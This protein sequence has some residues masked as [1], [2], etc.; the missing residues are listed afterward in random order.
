MLRSWRKSNQSGRGTTNSNS[1]SGS[2]GGGGGGSSGGGSGTDTR[3]KKNNK[4]KHQDD[5]GGN[6]TGGKFFRSGN[7]NNNR[8]GGKNPQSQPTTK[9]IRRTSDQPL[10]PQQ[11]ERSPP[12]PGSQENLYPRRQLDDNFDDNDNNTIG[13]CSLYT[14]PSL[15][16][17]QYTHNPQRQHPWQSAGGSRDIYDATKRS[18]NSEVSDDFTADVKAKLGAWQDFRRSEKKRDSQR[19]QQVQEPS[20]TTATSKDSNGPAKTKTK[21][22]SS[23]LKDWTA[24]SSEEKKAL[25]TTTNIKTADPQEDDAE[26]FSL[27]TSLQFGGGGGG[28][29]D[30]MVPDTVSRT[31]S[32]VKMKSPSYDHTGRLIRG[33]TVNSSRNRASRDGDGGGG[34]NS[35]ANL[36]RKPYSQPV[37]IDVMDDQQE[38]RGKLWSPPEKEEGGHHRTDRNDEDTVDDNEDASF[39]DILSRMEQESLADRLA[40]ESSH[41]RHSRSSLSRRT[42]IESAP[43]PLKHTVPLSPKPNRLYQDNASSVASS[44]VPSDSIN[45][46]LKS[47]Q[48]SHDDASAYSAFMN[49]STSTP[50]EESIIPTAES[51][52]GFLSTYE[53]QSLAVRLEEETVDGRTKNAVDMNRNNQ[54]NNPLIGQMIH[55]RDGS[56]VTS[57]GTFDVAG[58]ESSHGRPNHHPRPENTSVVLS[59]SSESL[60]YVPNDE[61]V[62]FAGLFSQMEEA[63]FAE[64]LDPDSKPILANLVQANS[65]SIEEMSVGTFLENGSPVTYPPR[66]DNAPKLMPFVQDTLDDLEDFIT[67]SP[68]EVQTPVLVNTEGNNSEAQQAS[69]SYVQIENDD[70]SCPPSDVSFGS[71]ESPPRPSVRSIAQSC[72]SKNAQ[73]SSLN[74]ENSVSSRDSAEI[75]RTD[76]CVESEVRTADASVGSQEENFSFNDLLSKFQAQDVHNIGPPEPR[77]LL[78][79]TDDDVPVV[80]FLTNEIINH[81]EEKKE[82][83]LPSQSPLKQSNLNHYKTKMYEPRGF[84]KERQDEH[85]IAEKQNG[86]ERKRLAT[87][88]T[89]ESRTPN[90]NDALSSQTV[91]TVVFKKDPKRGSTLS[92]DRREMSATQT[93]LEKKERKNAT[94]AVTSVRRRAN[95][96]SVS[97]EMQSSRSAAHGIS[98]PENHQT[99]KID[100]PIVRVPHN[101]QEYRQYCSESMNHNYGNVHRGP[102]D[103]DESIGSS[104]SEGNLDLPVVS[105]L[106]F[107]DGY[108]NR[109]HFGR[110]WLCDDDAI[111]D[112]SFVDMG[113]TKVL[114]QERIER[115]LKSTTQKIQA[116]ASSFHHESIR[117]HAATTT[118]QRRIPEQQELEAGLRPKS[119]DNSLRVHGSMTQGSGQKFNP[120]SS[121]MKGMGRTPSPHKDKDSGTRRTQN[122]TSKSTGSPRRFFGIFGRQTPKKEP[123]PGKSNTKSP[124]K[125]NRLPSQDVRVNLDTFMS[126]SSEERNDF[127]D[128]SLVQ[129]KKLDPRIYSSTLPQGSQHVDLRH[130]ENSPRRLAMQHLEIEREKQSWTQWEKY[131]YEETETDRISELRHNEPQRQG[132]LNNTHPPRDKSQSIFSPK[133]S[134][135]LHHP[136]A[137]TSTKDTESTNDSGGRIFL[138]SC[139]VCNEHERTHIAQPCNH[140]YFCG[141]CSEKIKGGA[142]CPICGCENVSFARVYT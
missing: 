132:R 141:P 142:C 40:V 10:P 118:I 29:S 102:V 49:A 38:Y 56:D 88:K 112:V 9:T 85:K 137:L 117:Y 55:T 41:H 76:G 15:A 46:I 36:H 107:E 28:G 101:S 63:S 20:T 91:N 31:P 44:S 86:T 127:A 134:V 21:T 80:D 8:N 34:A 119:A 104:T 113:D 75:T 37:D 61:D 105:P 22:V 114:T 100:I 69:D 77:R 94:K 96:V 72:E 124:N 58:S 140:F 128:I 27:S 43:S 81:E 64:K 83:E 111:L 87:T 13:D 120:Y 17:I 23:F 3:S 2:G 121:S 131:Q 70:D 67:G 16:T 71:V 14:T 98:S 60:S 32:P 103:L 108:K 93:S 78:A 5:V 138:G 116:P 62:S 106:G 129:M 25:L 68:E 30:M 73:F 59:D 99:G 54:L 66:I 24:R 74:K 122:S 11:R 90:K 52:A 50:T 12:P 97:P 33:N 1:G 125:K 35:N 4:K 110:E 47:S 92:R 82:D 95:V 133:P 84:M 53:E 115:H 39:S 139:V 7:S 19:Q 109:G 130:A 45:A 135:G 6:H 48:I 89:V 126:V 57:I 136:I 123:C 18:Y 26:E 42:G 51:F 65:S 79:G